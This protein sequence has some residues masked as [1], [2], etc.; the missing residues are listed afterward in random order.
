[1]HMIKSSSGH[2][3]SAITRP[4]DFDYGLDRFLLA[5]LALLDGLRRL[6][7]LFLDHGRP[8]Q[9]REQVDPAM[10]VVG[11]GVPVC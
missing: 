5:L 8:L 2:C 9:F 7:L 11:A 4:S 3:A 10:S 1:M 6:L